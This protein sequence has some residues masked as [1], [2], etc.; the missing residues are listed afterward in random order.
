MGLK[1]KKPSFSPEEMHI[2]SQN[3]RTLRLKN[4][5]T[6]MCLSEKIGIPFSTLAMYESGWANI[7]RTRLE[8]IGKFYGVNPEELTREWD[9]KL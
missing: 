1:G 3:L 4:G 7:S 6:L 2:I 8:E 5:F 9:E